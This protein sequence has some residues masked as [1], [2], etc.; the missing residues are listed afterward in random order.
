MIRPS[1]ASASLAFLALFAQ[2]ALPSLGPP[3]LAAPQEPRI[4]AQVNLVTVIASVLD[5]DGRPVPDLPKESF[6][7][8]EEGV[9]QQVEVF[10]AE[11]QQ[12]LDLALM[13]DS[14]LSTLM[15][16]SFERDAAVRFIQQIVRPGDRLAVFEVSDVVSQLAE[17]SSDVPRLEDAVRRIEGG[18]SAPLYDALVLGS[19]ALERRPLGRRRVLVLVTDGGE[20]ASRAK[21]DD[22]R[23]AAL[24]AGVMLYTILINPVKTE[25]GRN[26]GGEH[27][28]I[29]IT[30]V[31]GGSM[32][33]PRGGA[34]L[35]A[36]FD[37]MD[38]ELRT[39]YRLGYYPTP[40]PPQT[41]TAAF[42]RIEVR[43]HPVAAP[44][45]PAPATPVSGRFSVHHR[46]GYF[47]PGL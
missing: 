46:K 16:L 11:T 22:A 14:S 36:I 44:G 40:R 47:T 26:T 13:I 20:T 42:R 24:A 1:H 30:E 9:K 12:P 15:D 4:R 5:Q 31:T 37:R 8:Y 2:L 17:F 19:Q 7:V 10:E 25:G 33:F 27:A 3:R 29:T 28:L 23:R 32:Y 39:Q 43:V 34:D 41:T 21:F 38:R 35:N 45:E 6:E 18:G